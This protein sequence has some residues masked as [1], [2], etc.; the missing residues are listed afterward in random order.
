MSRT[1]SVLKTYEQYRPQ[2]KTGDLIAFSG[3]A[4][5]SHVIKWATRSPYSHVG[6]VLK[7]EMGSGFGDSILLIESTLQTTVLDANNKQAIK[8]MQMHWLSKRIDLYNG[9]VYWL[10]LKAPM[11]P[12]KKA[13]MEAWLRETHN[14]KVSY[15]YLQIYNAAI[16]WFD[17]LGLSNQPDFSTLFCS[18]LVAKALQIGGVIDPNINPSEKTPDDVV[19]FICYDQPVLLKSIDLVKKQEP[20]GLWGYIQKFLSSLL[21]SP[22]SESQSSPTE[23]N[24]LPSS[25]VSP[26]AS[27]SEASPTSAQSQTN[28]IPRIPSNLE[29]YEQYRPQMQT[30][31]LIAF[32][33][34]AGFSKVI[35][36][37]TKSDYS[38]VGIVVKSDLGNG[39]G[40]DSILIIEST[41]ATSL[42][43]ANN[44]QAI[45]GVQMHWLS[46]RI[47]MYNGSVSWLGLKNPIN[48][49]KKAEME[50]WLRET[51]NNKVPYDHV[52]IY[53]AAIDW[54][55]ELGLSNQP[56]FSTLFCSELVA[57]ALKIAGVI[58]P[59]INPSEQTPDD[60]IKYPCFKDAV[61]LKA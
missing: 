16:D 7:A 47:D 60:V 27:V 52:Q 24:S 23:T 5:F 51:H 37:A 38:H 55:D 28:I 34:N 6:I 9:S 48:P 42:L 45:K 35:K 32:S 25:E 33:G 20:S 8:G 14:Q 13:Q 12:E 30:G 44:K 39:F 58:D 46:K 4:G 29:V 50:A 10:Q 17:E 31:D 59:S 49:V 40:D 11:A 18:E 54:F 21:A 43:D 26:S 57:K 2:M 3:N 36:W 56:E 1:P 15:D 53:N 22:E 61:V 41:L 19:N